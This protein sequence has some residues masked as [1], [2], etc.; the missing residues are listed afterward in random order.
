MRSSVARAKI[1]NLETFRL[2]R[3]VRRAAKEIFD[4]PDGWDRFLNARA[5]FL[6]AAGDD[7]AAQQ[8]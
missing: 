1:V 6:D 8:R 3:A 2:E 5:R 4:Q 7:A